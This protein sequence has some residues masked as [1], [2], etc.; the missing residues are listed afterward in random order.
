MS[1]L[2]RLLAAVLAST[3]SPARPSPAGPAVARLRAAL[4]CMNRPY[5]ACRASIS[6]TSGYMG[7]PG[8]KPQL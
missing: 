5:D 3:H 1:L 7:E 2:R 4:R 6:T 8:K